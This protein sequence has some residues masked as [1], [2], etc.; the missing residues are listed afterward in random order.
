MRW[1][2]TIASVAIMKDRKIVASFS[3]AM[4]PFKLKRLRKVFDGDVW[5]GRW[6]EVLST[7]QR[8]QRH[9]TILPPI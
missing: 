2:R 9:Q 4:L 7:A 1:N 6:L 8:A 5:N 3:Q